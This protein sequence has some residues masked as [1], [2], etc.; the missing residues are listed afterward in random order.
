ME[1]TGIAWGGREILH[2]E[3]K[4]P[5]CVSSE[6]RVPA[7]LAV[8]CCA[9]DFWMG[10]IFTS[11]VDLK[12]LEN[13]EAEK[14]R[15]HEKEERQ[16]EREEEETKRL[17]DILDL[18]LSMSARRKRGSESVRRKRR[19]DSTRRKRGSESAR[20]KRR[21]DSTRTVKE[22]DSTRNACT[23]ESL[24]TRPRKER[25]SA[26]CKRESMRSKRRRGSTRRTS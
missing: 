6:R 19:R 24:K 12:K 20:R 21:R 14:K 3:A 11:Q 22:S 5:V 23:R 16:R 2:L 13:E 25:P 9:K 7:S 15:Q 1:G 8:Q 4:L 18:I 26:R 17:R 10:G